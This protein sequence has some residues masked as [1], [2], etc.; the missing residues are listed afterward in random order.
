MSQTAA[1]LNI[2]ATAPVAVAL[3]KELLALDPVADSPAVVD[4]A[5]L[6]LIDF[7]SCAFAARDLPWARQA[8]SVAARWPVA[9]G[10]T[11]IGTE[12]AAAPTEAAFV[13]SVMAAS[14]SRTDI[15]PAS[16]SH[17]AAIVF[18]VLL[19]LAAG[20]EIGGRDCIAAIV[21]GYEAMGRLGRIMVDGRFRRHFRATSVVGAVGGAVTAA[22]LLR[23]DPAKAVSALALS[24]NTAA[25]LMEWGHSGE[26]DLFY[27]PANAARAAVS[28]ALLAEAGASASPSIL[29]G[30]AGLLAAFGGRE[31]AHELLCR[32]DLR[33]EIELVDYK[34]VPACIFVQAAAHAAEDLVKRH[35]PDPAAV[36]EIT[37]RTFD[38][39]LSYPGCD[40][41]GPIDEIQPARMSLQH[42]VASVLGR[43]ELA[44]A[45][46]TDLAN[47]AVRRLVPHVQ[48]AA[49]PEFA[50]EFPGRQ[51]AEVAV[52]LR[53]GSLLT[54]R[55][56]DIPPFG[57]E[58]V[59][60]RFRRVGSNIMTDSHLASLESLAGQTHALT[61]ISGLLSALAVSAATQP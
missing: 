61:E 2:K 7:L 53:D 5:E 46:F 9:N 24:A 28:A 36:A 21:A 42:T 52:R 51:G 54:G 27:Q 48:L 15:H 23:M 44:D 22:R 55:V 11:I 35:R 4:K 6:C 40:N 20:R 10:A 8:I 60:K 57:R 26:V 1:A 19:A 39:A 37:V 32:G 41:P 56:D 13:N 25:G 33:R 34:P 12:V 29:D 14:A 58:Q 45:N 50:T 17:P 49:S 47:P 43:G 18:P 59:L 31:R 30:E 3:V 38:A 16:T